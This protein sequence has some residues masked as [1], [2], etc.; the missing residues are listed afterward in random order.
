MR[1]YTPDVWIIVEIHSPKHG[2]QYRVLAGW[3]GGYLYGDSWRLNSGIVEVKEFDNR[4]EFIGDSGSVYL[5]YKS[6]Q[7]TSGMTQSVLN[8]Y[9]AQLESLKDGSYIK[10]VEVK[11][12][13][14][15]I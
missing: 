13:P 2:T 6:A 4:Y 12:I 8:T 14:L 1:N 9:S 15:K 3:Y 11:D 5:C 10:E 7:R